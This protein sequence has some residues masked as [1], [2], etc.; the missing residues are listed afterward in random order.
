MHIGSVHFYNRSFP[1]D[2]RIEKESRAL[3]QAGHKVTVLTQK[4][5]DEEAEYEEVEPNFTIRRVIIKKSNIF[6]WVFS[7]ITLLNKVYESPIHKFINEYKPDVLHVNDFNPVPTVLKIAKDYKIPVVADLHENL[8]AFYMAY[9]SAFPFYKKWVHS[10]LYNYYL[11]RWHESRYLPQCAGVLVV[12]PEATDVLRLLGI[13]SK[14][15]IVVSNTEDETTIEI[16]PEKTDSRIMETYKDRWMVSYIGGI[17]PHRG[18]DTAIKALFYLKNRIPNFKLVIVG[19]KEDQE[20]KILTF[21]VSLDVKY[22]VQIVSW[23]PFEKVNSYIMASR[24]CLVPHDD[25]EHTHTTL[26]HKLFQ[27]MICSRPV[28]VSSC[29]PLK[30]VIEDTQAGVVFKASDPRNLA[31]KLVYMYKNPDKL[32]IM[33]NNGRK[34]ALGKYAW[35][36]DAKKLL[37]FYSTLSEELKK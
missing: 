31:D 16:T 22:L 23:Q 10:V 12:V 33:G 28:L 34:A 8:P 5:L 11:W 20:K 29:R 24:V 36:H 3:I 35:R 18:I 1:P 25:F 9:R 32:K 4:L 26:P 17:A 14:K 37:D 30:R 27:Y 6:S 7:K 21:A 15:I 19:A 13:N 2:I